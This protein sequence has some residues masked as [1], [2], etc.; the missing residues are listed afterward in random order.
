M[1][2]CFIMFYVSSIYNVEMEVV[3]LWVSLAFVTVSWT[4]RAEAH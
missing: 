4:S 2:D 1:H 3:I